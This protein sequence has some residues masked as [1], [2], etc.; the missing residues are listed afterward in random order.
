MPFLLEAKLKELG[1]HYERGDDWGAKA[2]V[3][4]RLVTGQNPQSSELC[5]KAVA[6]LLG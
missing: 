1:A 6:K 4:G 2:C 3:D 5:A